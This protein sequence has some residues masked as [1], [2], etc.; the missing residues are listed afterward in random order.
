MNDLFAPD[1]LAIFAPE[2]ARVFGIAPALIGYQISLLA[3]AMLVSLVFGGNPCVS[4]GQEFV[5]LAAKRYPG[6]SMTGGRAW[7]RRSGSAWWAAASWVC[8][9]SPSRPPMPGRSPSPAGRRPTRRWLVDGEVA[10]QAGNF[11][12]TSIPTG[13][14]KA[15][16]GWMNIA[17]IA[18]EQGA[19][20][21]AS[22]ASWK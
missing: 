8:A 17:A 13:V 2:V 6:K 16:D 12:P 10:G 9:T 4:F 14:Y 19:Q 11:H 20:A 3:C 21:M 15:R 1:D 7:R 22:V 5:G 18:G